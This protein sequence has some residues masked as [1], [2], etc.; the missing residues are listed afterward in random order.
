MSIIN[1]G[2]PVR[3]SDIAA[4]SD[5]GK[6]LSFTFNDITTWSV[7]DV[8]SYAI[9]RSKSS[10][11]SIGLRKRIAG[12][13]SFLDSNSVDGLKLIW[14]VSTPHETPPKS[15]SPQVAGKLKNL[16]PELWK[17]M[18]WK[19]LLNPISILY[20]SPGETRLEI[21]QGG[22]MNILIP[23][24]RGVANVLGDSLPIDRVYSMKTYYNT[25]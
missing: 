16:D 14:L 11:C 9:M 19:D 20:D 23:N 21:R 2:H 24:E 8:I 3:E 15:N 4:S 7:C 5:D 22:N 1:A 18:R 6:I 10:D 17:G 25:Q 12:V 13:I